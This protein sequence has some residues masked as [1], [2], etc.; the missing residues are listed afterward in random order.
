M[1]SA[2]ILQGESEFMTSMKGLE[3]KMNVAARNIVTKGA[4]I[5]SDSAKEQFR[6]RPTGS[7]RTSK[8]TGRVYYA[9]APSFPA[10]PPMPTQRT[11]NLRNSIRMQSVKSL[12][13]GRWQSDTG[14]SVQYGGY[15][16]YGTSR[17]RPFPY[18]TNGLKNADERIRSL[19]QEEWATAQM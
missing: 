6:A 1:A 3:E 5:I 16:N 7:Q 18:M 19:A 17:A 14:P 15:V 13:T 12:G 2:I 8:K 10:Q 4:I 11:G 9:G